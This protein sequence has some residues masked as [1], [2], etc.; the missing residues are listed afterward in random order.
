MDATLMCARKPTKKRQPDEH[1][2][3]D[4]ASKRQIDPDA[5]FTKKGNTS[6]FGYKGHVNV[7]VKHK[8]VRR[9]IVTTAST[10]DSQ[11]MLW[12]ERNTKKVFYGDS[13]YKNH[14]MDDHLA[15]RAVVN[16]MNRRAYRGKS[17][18]GHDERFNRTSSR[19]RCRIEHVF[20]QV[21]VWGRKI[22]LRSIGLARAKLGI[23]MK[24]LVYNLARWRLLQHKQQQASLPA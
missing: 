2:S 8:I 17:L 20:G 13:A 7:D 19:I 22:Q 15:Q 23:G 11:V 16:R 1:A 12:D 4:D 10:H 18:N 21:K 14:D 24:F 9:V 5:T 3:L 6:Y